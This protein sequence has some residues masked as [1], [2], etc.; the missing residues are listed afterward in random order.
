VLYIKFRQLQLLYGITDTALMLEQFLLF[1]NVQNL[2]RNV[3]HA[4]GFVPQGS[5]LH[6]FGNADRHASI[7]RAIRHGRPARKDFSGKYL[8]LFFSV[9]GFCS[10]WIF[11]IQY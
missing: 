8:Y 2:N 1:K 9:V 7:S 3:Y 11:C 5:R 6:L 4:I 10:R